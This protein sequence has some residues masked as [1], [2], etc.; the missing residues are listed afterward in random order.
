M[1]F[2]NKKRIK[3]GGF[4]KIFT[5]ISKKPV[6]T[7]YKKN[8]KLYINI[9]EGNEG[10][11]WLGE[12]TQSYLPAKKCSSFSPLSYIMQEAM[13]QVRCFLYLWAKKYPQAML[14]DIYLNKTFAERNNRQK[15]AQNEPR[16]F[17]KSGTKGKW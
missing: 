3:K 11:L 10:F 7:L 4:W 16:G 17:F 12:G 8:K 5:K 2:F 13:D 6:K 14:V 1:I 9:V 15:K